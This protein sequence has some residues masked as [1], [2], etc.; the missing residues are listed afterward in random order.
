MRIPTATT[1][2]A[3]FKL[4]KTKNMYNKIKAPKSNMIVNT[5]YIGEALELKIERIM[6]TN[7]PI[8][9]TAPL[10]YTERKEG[11]QPQYDIRTD[12]WD[13]AIDAMD[14][15]A[16][17]HKAKRE[18]RGKTIGEEARDNMAKEAKT[19]T[20]GNAGTSANTSDK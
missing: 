11:V 7:E 15:V 13:I 9:D 5:S 19:E 8:S 20:K 18:Q 3:Y 1:N 2:N 4:L 12:R 10:I 17:T 6:T 14:T 16:K